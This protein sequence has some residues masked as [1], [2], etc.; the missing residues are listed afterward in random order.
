MIFAQIVANGV[1]AIIDAPIA[2]RADWTGTTD[3]L[4]R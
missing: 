2:A 3:G 4:G 1:I